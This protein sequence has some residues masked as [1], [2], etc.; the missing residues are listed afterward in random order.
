MSDL[1]SE[2]HEGEGRNLPG[3]DGLGYGA[4]RT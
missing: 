2:A 4:N 3:R 1:T